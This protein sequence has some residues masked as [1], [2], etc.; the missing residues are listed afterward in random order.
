MLLANVNGH[1]NGLNLLNNKMPSLGVGQLQGVNEVRGLQVALAQ[2]AMVTQRPQINPNDFSGIVGASTVMA[3]VSATDLLSEHLSTMQFV[4]LKI[5]LAGATFSSTATDA[6][7][8]AIESSAL[9]LTVAANTAAAK[10][11]QPTPFGLTADWW[12]TPV[13]LGLIAIGVIV[14]IKVLSKPKKP[15]TL[16]TTTTTT[17]EKAA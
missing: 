7:K 5:A 1:L 3:V 16:S 8:R 12:T 11:G 13:G 17:T 10:F 9:A 15:K 14:G 2:L 6:A 4:A